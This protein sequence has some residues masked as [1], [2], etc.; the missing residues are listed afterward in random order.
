MFGDC[1]GFV[2]PAPG[3]PPPPS[4]VV[5]SDSREMRALRIR[6]TEGGTAPSF[7]TQ[8]QCGGGG[9]VLHGVLI[10][11]VSYWQW[12][13]LRGNSPG[14]LKDPPPPHHHYPNVYFR[15][16]PM[17]SKGNEKASRR[18][19][20]RCFLITTRNRLKRRSRKLS[21]YEGQSADIVVADFSPSSI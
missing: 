9:E 4:F 14:A 18:S 1:S 21:F 11:K 5:L 8:A 17:K 13:G 2:Q 7:F 16:F 19:L 3:D 12:K 10:M 15:L 6:S 20:A